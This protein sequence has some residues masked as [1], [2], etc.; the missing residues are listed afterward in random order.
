MHAGH[1]HSRFAI[2]YKRGERGKRR[3]QGLEDLNAEPREEGAFPRHSR[4]MARARGHL[5]S[6]AQRGRVTRLTRLVKM[7]AGEEARVNSLPLTGAWRFTPYDSQ[8]C[9]SSVSSLPS[10]DCGLEE[11]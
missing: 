10:A 6:L 9:S 1:S 7:I 11:Q 8:E 5:A 2:L 3:G 4:E